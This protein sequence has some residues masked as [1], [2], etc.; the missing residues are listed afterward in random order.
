MKKVLF[1]IIGLVLVIIVAFSIF[2]YNPNKLTPENPE[3]K[4]LYY[5]MI[6][7]EEVKLGDNQRYE[8]KLDAFDEK[9]EKKTLTFTSSKHLQEGAFL[10]LYVAPFRGVTYWKELL[11]DEL[12]DKIQSIYSS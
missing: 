7:N 8:Y 1:G 12:P 11:F 2:F 6:N 3:G 9:G 10:E 5:S 4:T